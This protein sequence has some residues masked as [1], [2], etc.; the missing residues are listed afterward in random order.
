MKWHYF[1]CRKSV[2]WCQGRSRKGLHFMRRDGDCQLTAFMLLTRHF[3]ASDTEL[4]C[5]VAE[6]VFLVHSASLTHTVISYPHVSWASSAARE[7]IKTGL[8]FAFTTILYGGHN[9]LNFSLKIKYILPNP[10]LS[11]AHLA[12]ER[13]HIY[14]IF[15]FEMSVRL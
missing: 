13:S 12:S 11:W 10:I 9:K 3:L 5:A 7:N 14:H 6:S 4:C 2:S 15:S 1:K 8:C